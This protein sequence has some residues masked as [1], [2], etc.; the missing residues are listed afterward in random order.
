MALADY[1]FDTTISEVAPEQ[2]PPKSLKRTKTRAG[3]MIS[4]SATAAGVRARMGR[5]VVSAFMVASGITLVAFG[6]DLASAHAFG[7]WLLFPIGVYLSVTGLFWMSKL[8]RSPQVLKVD[9]K[10]RA[11][12][13]I[14][15][16]W[17]GEE[18]S[19][20][21]IR[22][23]EVG[24]ITL[25]ENLAT[26]DMRANA[27]NWDLGRIDLTWRQNK[28]T[29]LISGDLAELEPLLLNL[30]SEAGLG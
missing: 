6:D 28:V 13:L 11:F 17:R 21:T 15:R 16:N 8:M 22:F 27:L 24:K 18:R 20:K 30:R 12:H 1:G 10:G 5:L 2:L 9:Q 29:P 4:P 14:K 23:E 19:R 7:G 26:F 25:V 3:Y